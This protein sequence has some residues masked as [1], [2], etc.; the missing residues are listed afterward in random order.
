MGAT[1]CV[2]S[3]LHDGSLMLDSTVTFP[4]S[5]ANANN[6]ANFKNVLAN[7]VSSV[8]PA[9]TYGAVK[10]G[11]VTSTSKRHSLFHATSI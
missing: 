1:A 5:D 10:V 11:N 6:A 9:A 4:K 7:N 2:L 3:K 8:F